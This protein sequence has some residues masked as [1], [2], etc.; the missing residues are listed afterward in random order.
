VL[1]LKIMEWLRSTLS[2]AAPMAALV[3]VLML[4]PTRH[5]AAAVVH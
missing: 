1:R 2:V 5:A 3:L 4:D